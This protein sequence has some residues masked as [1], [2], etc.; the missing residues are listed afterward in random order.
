MMAVKSKSQHSQAQVIADQP[1]QVTF[2]DTAPLIDGARSSKL[3]PYEIEIEK[4]I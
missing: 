4:S 1:I 2:P 3:Q